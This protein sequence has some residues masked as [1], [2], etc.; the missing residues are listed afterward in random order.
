MI[1]P[2]SAYIAILEAKIELMDRRI[3]DAEATTEF[4]Q[5]L[6]AKERRRNGESHVTGAAEIVGLDGSPADPAGADR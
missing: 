5:A 1:D 4:Y 3:A 2:A 6:Y